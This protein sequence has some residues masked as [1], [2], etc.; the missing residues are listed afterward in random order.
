MVLFDKNN[1]TS[2]FQCAI[3]PNQFFVFAMTTGSGGHLEERLCFDGDEKLLLIMQTYN[4]TIFVT[5]DGNYTRIGHDSVREFEGFPSVTKLLIDPL[6]MG[7]T[8]K[9]LSPSIADAS[10]DI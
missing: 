5:Y 9:V 7:R 6:F 3:L 8:K 4:S 2:S 1:V 10:G